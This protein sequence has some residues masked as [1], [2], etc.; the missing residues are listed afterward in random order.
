M[1]RMST[2]T[3][4]P[5]VLH[6]SVHPI[7]AKDAWM[8]MLPRS[9]LPRTRVSKPA[10]A[11]ERPL[12]TTGGQKEHLLAEASIRATHTF[13]TAQRAQQLA[14]DSHPPTVVQSR[15]PTF[16]IRAAPSSL[17]CV[18]RQEK[19]GPLEGTYLPSCS[20]HRLPQRGSTG[21]QLRHQSV[22]SPIQRGVEGTR[23]SRCERAE[24]M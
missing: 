16:L 2:F 23:T 14:F 4:F 8:A 22:L 6:R 24:H 12:A 18:P 13:Q 15:W 17:S 7:V 21:G 11:P 20:S 10:H 3:S 19:A 9:P 5:Y 1:A